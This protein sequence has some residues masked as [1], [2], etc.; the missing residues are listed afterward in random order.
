VPDVRSPTGIIRASA[1]ALHGDDRATRPLWEALYGAGA[2][3]VIVGH[4]HLYERFAPQDPDGKLDAVRGIR[5]FVVGTGGGEAMSSG[6]VHATA[7]RGSARSAC[8]S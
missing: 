6:P 1:Q 8:C 2:E 3:I 4:D 7:M 5:E